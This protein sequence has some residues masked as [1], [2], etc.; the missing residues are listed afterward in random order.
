M[1]H[2]RHHY[3]EALPRIA[4]EVWLLMTAYRLGPPLLRRFTGALQFR[5]ARLN[6]F[7]LDAI[8]RHAGPAATVERQCFLDHF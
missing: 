1:V 8:T 4:Q 2:P 7:D 6:V 5:Y 3:S